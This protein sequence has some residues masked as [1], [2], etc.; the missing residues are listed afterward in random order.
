MNQGSE[1]C[2]LRPTASNMTLHKSRSVIL[3]R[4]STITFKYKSSRKC[5]FWAS[6]IIQISPSYLKGTPSHV[7]PVVLRIKKTL[8][9]NQMQIVAEYIPRQQNLPGTSKNITGPHF[10]FACVTSLSTLWAKTD[11]NT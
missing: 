4:N 8:I 7:L 10:K 5:H 6:H 3:A 9:Q 2:Y 1:S 11:N